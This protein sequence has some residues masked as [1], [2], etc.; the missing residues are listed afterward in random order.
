MNNIIN[1]YFINYINIDNHTNKYI[2][3][4]NF[5]YFLKNLIF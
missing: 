5:E 2:N 4:K 1:F 3:D